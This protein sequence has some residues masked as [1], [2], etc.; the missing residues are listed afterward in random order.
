MP[1]GAVLYGMQPGSITVRCMRACYGVAMNHE[2]TDEFK[3]KLG[4][5]WADHTFKHEET[6]GTYVRNVFKK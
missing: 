1:A 3:T 5:R 6:H 2:L 4:H